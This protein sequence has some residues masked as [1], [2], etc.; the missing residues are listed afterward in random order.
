MSIYQ[1]VND[2]EQS[3]Y[4]S[5]D[6]EG[7]NVENAVKRDTVKLVAERLGRSES[8]IRRYTTALEKE[9][10]KFVRQGKTRMYSSEDEEILSKMIQCTEELE[11]SV[12]MAARTVLDEDESLTERLKEVKETNQSNELAVRDF[13][14]RLDEM[15]L[16]LKN[17]FA[18]KKD[19]EQLASMFE[20]IIQQDRQK[21]EM[22]QLQTEIIQAQ[23]EKVEKLTS[24]VETSN[25]QTVQRD[26]VIKQLELSRKESEKEKRELA[27]K[28]EAMI[29][30][31]NKMLLRMQEER[32]QDRIT[33]KE[34]LEAKDEENLKLQTRLKQTLDIY[35]ETKETVTWQS[36]KL[37][38]IGSRLNE[39]N[40]KL[41]EMK[42]K[43]R[44]LASLFSRNK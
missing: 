2:R 34:L 35:D 4:Q 16:V 29:Q 41:E 3:G 39:T 1:S 26:E 40:D 7:S 43:K 37:T 9:G 38:E 18:S 21:S 27:S 6:S 15:F 20:L 19:V 13:G 8:T 33:Y 36:E 10:R 30:E 23:N 25:Q 28:A 42:N 17:N 14:Q 5:T 31:Q 32:E 44:G 24:L 12:E 11:L 22:I